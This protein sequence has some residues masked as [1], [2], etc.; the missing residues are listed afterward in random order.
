MRN[1]HY[2][3]YMMD[4]ST[5]FWAALTLFMVGAWLCNRIHPKEKTDE[6]VLGGI[7]ISKEPCLGAVNDLFGKGVDSSRACDCLLPAYYELVKNDPEE[8]TK[9]KYIGIHTLPGV[10]NKQVNQ[11][12]AECISNHI[13][14]SSHKMHF[15]D[16]NAK[17]FRQQLA[18]RMRTDTA[19]KDLNPDSLA[20]CLV[21]RLND[22]I[23][24]VDY[25]GLSTWTDATV[26]ALIIPC[27]VR[28]R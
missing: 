19:Y 15:Q 14:D 25:I 3:S 20:A 27:I 16:R 10:R 9:F 12:F 4:N 28:R 21:N 13:I 24:V 18:D 6:M 26:K 11:L 23:T 17:L 7:S 1:A 22:H 8:L 5:K 2:L